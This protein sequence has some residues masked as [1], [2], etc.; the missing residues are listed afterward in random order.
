[1]KSTDQTLVLISTI[2][3]ILETLRQT[4]SF[5]RVDIKQSIDRGFQAAQQA[6]INYPGFANREWIKE[7]REKFNEFIFATPDDGF[8]VAALVKMMDRVSV[9]LMERESGVIR[10]MAMLEPIYAVV[11]DLNDFV[12]RDGTNFPAFEKSDQ[13]LDRL[14][15]IIDFK[16]EVV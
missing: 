13:L 9:D 8:P 10:K 3:G 5:A 14:Y 1:M 4:H 16:T 7:R 6:I 12:D 15:S 11:R 2:A